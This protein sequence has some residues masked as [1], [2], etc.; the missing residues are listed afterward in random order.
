MSLS[1]KS[2]K[3]RGRPKK[4]ATAEQAE[5]GIRQQRQ[6][7]YT[8]TRYQ[9]STEFIPYEPLLPTNVPQTTPPS[10]GLRISPEIQ[11]LL[12]IAREENDKEGQEEGEEYP[13]E[14]IDC[15]DVRGFTPLPENDADITRQIAQTQAIEREQ[16]PEVE[17][18]EAAIQDQLRASKRRATDILLEI[19]GGNT[20]A[21]TAIP[22]R[23]RGAEEG[24]NNLPSSAREAAWRGGSQAERGEATPQHQRNSQRGE[25]VGTQSLAEPSER[26]AFKLAKQLRHFQGCTHEQ[27]CKADAEHHEHHLRADVHSACSSL[28]TITALLSSGQHGCIRMPDVLSNPKLMK[29]TDVRG[30]DCKSI[31][32][33]TS[34]AALPEEAGTSDEGLPHSLCL[35]QHHTKS[36][37]KRG[38][39]TT[40]D[41]DSICCFPSSLGD[42]RRGIYWYPKPHAFLNLNADIHFAMRVPAYNLRGDLVEREMPLHHIPHY[43]FGS[44]CNPE[45]I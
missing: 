27:H 6:V 23:A 30:V 26:T 44:N 28:P 10:I 17:E 37:K 11:A 32:E 8:R 19:A 35:S 34:L 41:V 22:G 40:F 39:Q 33:G 29:P 21:D 13:K 45:I 42:A 12:A 2:K 43:C 3:P 9:H 4:Y 20:D 24:A 36:R 31:F 5:D 16:A 38:A 7:R 15:E 25:S 1:N 14:R 18:R